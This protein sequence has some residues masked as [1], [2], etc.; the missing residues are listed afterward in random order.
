MKSCMCNRK[1]LQSDQ[2]GLNGADRNVINVTTRPGSVATSLTA[3]TWYVLTRKGHLL[4][5]MY[6]R[7]KELKVAMTYLIIK[8]SGNDL[9][10]SNSR[11]APAIS[12]GYLHYPPAVY[13]G[14]VQR[15]D[16]L[17]LAAEL[18]LI[19]PPA[20]MKI[21]NPRQ[22][23]DNG[24]TSVEHSVQLLYLANATCQYQRQSLLLNLFPTP[25]IL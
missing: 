19:F 14:I 5:I 1:L 3:T 23:L 7:S 21:T 10:S 4:S 12:L 8:V 22:K 25:K 24:S 6:I 15:V 20:S 16:R 18:P 11:M 9:D 13:M 17:S 2:R